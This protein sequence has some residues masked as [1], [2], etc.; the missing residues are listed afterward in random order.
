[1]LNDELG[2]HRTQEMYRLLHKILSSYIFYPVYAQYLF[3]VEFALHFI[4]L[5]FISEHKP[6]SS[7]HYL[8][9]PEQAKEMLLHCV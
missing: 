5:K 2:K 3:S 4:A 7:E 1:M 9:K 6:V 8:M